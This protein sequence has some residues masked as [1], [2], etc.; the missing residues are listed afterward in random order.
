[1]SEY[2]ERI[3][4]HLC[5]LSE[6]NAGAKAALRRSLAFEPGRDASVFPYLER[7]TGRDWHERDPRRLATYAVAGL[8]ALLPSHEKSQSFA[9]ACGRLKRARSMHDQRGDGVE[10]RFVSLLNADAENVVQYVR[11]LLSM[12]GSDAVGFDYVRLL[13]DLTKWMNPLPGRGEER[14]RLRERWARDY[15]RAAFDEQIVDTDNSQ[16][17]EER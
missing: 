12:M 11:Q 3:V 13:D 15:V 4:N 8:F 14:D 16:Q 7:F 1:M 2:A 10:R 17:P 6:Q 9:G 5:V